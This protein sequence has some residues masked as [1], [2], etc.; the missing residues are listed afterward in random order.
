MLMEFPLNGQGLQ[1]CH[2]PLESRVIITSNFIA[3]II[4]AD[5]R[6][7][8]ACTLGAADQSA[9]QDL[10]IRSWI[11]VRVSVTSGWHIGAR[12]EMRHYGFIAPLTIKWRYILPRTVM[13]PYGRIGSKSNDKTAAS[14]TKS[15]VNLFLSHQTISLRVDVQ[16]GSLQMFIVI[17][18][19]NFMSILL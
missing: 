12:A 2:S 18:R 3:N 14:V 15:V 8:V 9:V 17:N 19:M 4:A 13:S 6:I 16:I 1:S 7:S 5:I 11:I 10:V